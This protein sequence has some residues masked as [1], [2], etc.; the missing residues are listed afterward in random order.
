MT[1]N[2]D[3]PFPMGAWMQGEGTFNWKSGAVIKQRMS[4]ATAKRIPAEDQWGQRPDDISWFDIEW[5]DFDPEELAMF[6]WK[7]DPELGWPLTAEDRRAQGSHGH[8]HGVLRVVADYWQAQGNYEPSYSA[9]V[10]LLL[11]QCV[12]D[13][14][15]RPSFERMLRHFEGAVGAALFNEELRL[16]NEKQVATGHG[17][18]PRPWRGGPRRAR[19]RA[20]QTTTATP[21]ARPSTPTLMT[22][23]E[24][25]TSNPMRRYSPPRPNPTKR[26]AV[27]PGGGASP[28]GLAPRATRCAHVHAGTRGIACVGVIPGFLRPKPDN[29][30]V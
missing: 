30:S 17:S 4:S 27:T 20:P 25:P 16:Y 3:K 13:G 11:H 21:V 22:C 28:R 2:R 18:R 7:G 23:I 10:I 14:I 8:R 1:N 29:E 15:R 5:L 6:S 19:R 24:L 9:A 12:I 26:V